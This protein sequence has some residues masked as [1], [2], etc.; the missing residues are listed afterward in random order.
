M[1]EDAKDR[2]SVRF[3]GHALIIEGC[4][5]EL[6]EFIAERLRRLTAL[7]NLAGERAVYEQRILDSYGQG[8]CDGMGL[9]ADGQNVT[10]NLDT[11][12]YRMVPKEAAT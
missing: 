9:T 12:T 5:V 1:S 11:M 8:V 10:V 3:V 2:A 4:D 6:P 7:R